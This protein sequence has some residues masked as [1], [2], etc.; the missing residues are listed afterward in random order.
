MYT[1]LW[2]IAHTPE[3][4]GTV[5]LGCLIKTASYTKI[6]FLQIKTDL[7][8]LPK[9]NPMKKLF[10]L[11]LLLICLVMTSIAQNSGRG[12]VQPFQYIYDDVLLKQKIQAD[13]TIADRYLIYEQNMREIIAA[14]KASMA[15][16]TDTLVGGKRIIPVVFHIV[17]KGGPENIS[18][19]QILDA[20]DLLNKDYNKLNSDTDASH[21]YPAF[22]AL[23]ADCQIEFRLAKIDPAG[24]CTNGIMRHY[25]PQ[26]NYGYFSTMTE[27]CWSPSR[28][29]NIFT[30][31]FIYPEGIALPEGAFIGGMSPFPP[32]NPLSQSL[33][34]GDTL[35]DGV[36]IR[37]DG[38]GSI[39]TATTLGGMPI[40]ALNRTFTHE[41]GHYFNLYH[42]FQTGVLC[43]LLGM[44]GCGSSTWG[45]GDEVDDTPPVQT[46]SQNTSVSCFTPGSRNTCHNDS[47]DV[48][49]MIENYMDYQWGYCTNLFTL[50]QLDRVNAT[51]QN[52]RR[53]LWSKENLI[54][55]GVLDTNAGHCA[56]VADFYSN[57]FMLCA[58]SSV[59][60]SDQS[61]GAPVAG[62]IWTF[63]GGNPAT[64]T[65]PSPIVNYANPGVYSVTLKVSNPQGSDSLTRQDMI[66]V[67]STSGGNVAP[68]VE[69][70][71]TANLNNGWMILNDIG[72]TWQISDTA[73][74]TGTKCLRLN[75]FS[76]N[77][78][79]SFDEIITPAFDLT[80]LPTDGT[81]LVKFRL[82]YAGK[83]SS[84][85]LSS[86]TVY[87][88]LKMYVS[89]DCGKTWNEKFSA[90][91]SDLGTAAP[92]SSSFK[93]AGQSDWVEIT[94]MLPYSYLSNDHVIFRFRF[95]SNAGNNIYI[96]DL[97]V[98]STTVGMNE[99][100]ASQLNLNVVPNPMA[101][102]AVLSFDLPVSAQATLSV[103]D[104]TG[105]EVFNIAD[106]RL[107]PGKHSY[108]IERKD[109]GS[110]GVYFV[111]A[112]F[113][114]YSLVRKIVLQ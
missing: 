92:R 25:D 89:T 99:E 21:T 102:S 17:H 15:N 24:N 69:S 3:K 76:G 106:G 98:S 107:L 47:P 84:T 82:A 60:F 75:N 40:N 67:K 41:S 55:T 68:F 65:D 81:P 87:D 45:C 12:N 71:E 70:F 4:N 113:D 23:R 54:A 51:M 5:V 77:T 32:S 43:T 91:G 31:N 58:G 74:Y 9:N 52:D 109:L 53:K 97:N 14:Q 1:I 6:S 7:I 72:G 19:A 94:R 108:A 33:T 13:P 30:V 10:T 20:I 79:G 18:E 59:T 8:N 66:I 50:G 85:L 2:F 48:P 73:S 95:H 56:P 49:D 28:Y 46:A 101:T 36:L 22:G 104:L 90:D 42:P 112:G 83:I 103:F 93:P 110:A 16:K 64:S 61:Y 34:G 39:G 38:I 62:R 78:A 27:Y 114:G 26:T 86:D 105:R 44:D 100:M 96:D 37:H 111:K 35:A 57:A 29:L 80:Q 63:P 11:S 88:E